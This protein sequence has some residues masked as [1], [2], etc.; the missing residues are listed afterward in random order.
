MPCSYPFL[1]DWNEHIW[2]S[3]IQFQIPPVSSK[4]LPKAAQ[5]DVRG[6]E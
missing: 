3:H 5:C 6:L 1:L 2:V 4:A